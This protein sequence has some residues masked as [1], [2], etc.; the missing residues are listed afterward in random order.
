MASVSPVT[1]SVVEAAL[2]EELNAHVIGTE[3]EVDSTVVAHTDCPRSGARNKSTV[4]GGASFGGMNRDGWP[5]FAFF[6]VLRL[7]GREELLAVETGT[8]PRQANVFEALVFEE[9]HPDIMGAFLKGNFSGFSP[10]HRADTFDFCNKFSIDKNG[11]AIIGIDFESVVTSARNVEF[12]FPDDSVFVAFSCF[13]EADEAVVFFF[14]GG[15]FEF[16]KIGACFPRTMIDFGDKVFDGGSFFPV[17]VLKGIFFEQ[18]VSLPHHVAVFGSLAVGNDV[19]LCDGF[20]FISPVIPDV[21]EDGNNLRVGEGASLRGHNEVEGGFWVFVGG[22]LDFSL[23]SVEDDLDGA[24]RVTI[25]P[26]TVCQWGEGSIVS[27]FS[28]RGMAC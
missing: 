13:F 3:C 21:I 9:F 8:F 24:I 22:D 10:T 16:G 5:L 7:C 6:P 26:W 20:V 2:P 11:R 23:K 18:F 27:S 28:V 19:L 15:G 1:A 17:F 25:E 4:E 14:N 12:T